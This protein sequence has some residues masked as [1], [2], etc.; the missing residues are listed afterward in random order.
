M[1]DFEI[2]QIAYLT[3][4]HISGTSAC[5]GDSGGSMTFEEGGSYYIRGIVSWIV[6]RNKGTID[7][8][9]LCD[10]NEYVTFTDVAQYLPWIKHSNSQIN[11]I[12]CEK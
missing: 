2:V 9:P 4:E 12:Q 6:A 5:S 8:S 1:P 10:S 7:N 3:L 11:G